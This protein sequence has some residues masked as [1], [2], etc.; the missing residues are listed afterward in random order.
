M[1]IEFELPIKDLLKQFGGGLPDVVD[2][3]YY[4]NLPVEYRIRTSN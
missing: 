2:Y 1:N 3:Q 4:V